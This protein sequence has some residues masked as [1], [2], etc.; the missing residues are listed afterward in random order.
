[1]LLGRKR[2][3]YLNLRRQ[4]QPESIK[5]VIVAES[6]PASGLYFYDP[7]GSVGEPLFSAF[8]QQIGASPKDKEEGLCKFQQRGWV[9]TDATYKPVNTLPGPIRDAVIEQDY[10]SLR[11]DL[12]ALLR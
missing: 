3:E 8:M 6:P 9:V 2:D 1:M 4:Y 11:E 5:L 12:A 10:P 7:E